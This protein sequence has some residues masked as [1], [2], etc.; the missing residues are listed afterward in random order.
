MR[1]LRT[2]TPA[3]AVVVT[4]TALLAV[5]WLWRG[6]DGKGWKEIVRSDAKGYYG[7][8]TATFIRHD[9]GHEP[10]V[11]EFIHETPDGTLNKYFC[12]ASVMMLP[13]WAVGHGLALLDEG[14]PRD[15]HSA[16]EYKAVSVGVWVYLL[17]GLLMLRALLA[18]M[19]VRDAVIAWLILSLGLGTTLLQYASQQPAW[20]HVFTFCCVSAF[21]LLVRKLGDGDDRRWLV[22]L[23]LVTALI[24]LI[25]PVNATVLLAVPIVLGRDTVPTL[26][27]VPTARAT[28]VVALLAGLAVLFIQPLWW[29]A[30]TGHW[31]EW[32]YR[33]EGFHWDR[34]EVFKVL[35]G[36]RRGLFLWT[37]FF[38][39]CAAAVVLLWWRDRIRALSALA[40]WAVNVYLISAWWIW[41]YGS[42][43]GSRVFIDHYPVLV[44]PLALVLQGWSGRKWGLARVFMAGCIA[45]HLVQF[46]QYHLKIIHH[47][48][49]DRHK[50]AATFLRFGK[51]Y[52]DALGGN[53]QAPPYNPNGMRVVLEERDDLETDR[54]WWHGGTVE[55]RPEARS[56]HHVCVF[57]PAI[58]F[59]RTFEATAAQ[60]PTGQWL[61]LEVSMERY[62]AK[63]RDSHSAQCVTSIERPDGSFAFYDPFR[64]NPLP[65][66]KDGTWEHIEYRIPV[67][68]LEPG[69]KL[70]FY[71]WNQHRDARF[72][73]DDLHMK[74]LAVNPY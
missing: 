43:F 66:T 29:H 72:L 3:I 11:H 41:Y 60:L 50:Y 69:D 67:P 63:A 2:S 48:S 44:L 24:G 13:W 46:T 49:M 36:F 68:P 1:P 15:G 55:V 17:L 61:Y 38:L 10:F 51:P 31:I 23:A 34:P 30:Q 5:L 26:R 18:R 19:G 25:R 53:H 62:E 8:L 64:M 27:A 9:L 16:Y 73:L 22:P 14:A 20:T 21:L 54:R 40:Y 74:V 33:G 28:L 57:T 6:A 47:E 32:G 52:E 4:A 71:V 39:G 35:F 12:G 58:E 70:K 45:L 56:P 59:G 7:Y 37:P 65:G 42:G